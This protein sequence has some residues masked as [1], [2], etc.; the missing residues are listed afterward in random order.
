MTISYNPSDYP[1]PLSDAQQDALLE[2][3]Q[4]EAD[5][6]LLDTMISG[7]EGFAEW[8]DLY[9]GLGLSAAEAAEAWNS[10]GVG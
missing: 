3:G 1:L 4:A 2:L 9:A 6:Q 10:L 8:V 5:A 7:G